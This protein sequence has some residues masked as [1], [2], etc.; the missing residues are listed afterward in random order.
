MLSQ[1]FNSAMSKTSHIFLVQDCSPLNC[2]SVHT[3]NLQVSRS[4][5]ISFLICSTSYSFKSSL[6]SHFL[7]LLLPTTNHITGFNENR[8]G[9]QNSRYFYIMFVAVDVYS[10]KYTVILPPQ[11]IPTALAH[12]QSCILTIWSSFLDKSSPYSL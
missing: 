3:I 12:A 4:L 5:I 10:H 7:P 1:C 6:S 11:H 8:R 2:Y 9:V